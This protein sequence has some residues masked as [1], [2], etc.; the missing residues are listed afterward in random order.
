MFRMQIIFQRALLNV[1]RLLI[2]S[3]YEVISHFDKSFLEKHLIKLFATWP[4][5]IN[6]YLSVRSQLLYYSRIFVCLFC[7]LALFETLSI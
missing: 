4:L 3:S 5:T 2:V 1:N 6:L 7:I